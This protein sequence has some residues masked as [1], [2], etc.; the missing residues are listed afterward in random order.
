MKRLFYILILIGVIAVLKI[1]IVEP[2]W[3]LGESMEPALHEGRIYLVNK[4]SYR[5][6]EPKRGEVVSFRTTDD[7]PLFFVKRIVGLPGERIEMREGR[8]LVNS[9]PLDEPYTLRNKDWNLDLL[10]IEEGCVYMMG[11]NRTVPMDL[12]LSCEVSIS[13]LKGPIIGVR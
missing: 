11:D 4:I 7:P 12:Q 10:D 8:L 3:I 6:R 1:Y 2:V 13:N 5:F 9:E